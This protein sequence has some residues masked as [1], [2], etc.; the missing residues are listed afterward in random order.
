MRGPQ[1]SDTVSDTCI[2]RSG[3][4]GR[5]EGGLPTSF[6]SSPYRRNWC[7]RPGC[8]SWCARSTQ[9]VVVAFFESFE[10][11]FPNAFALFA[12]VPY[13]VL[14]ASRFSARS[15]LHVLAAFSRAS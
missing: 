9:P 13:L 12:F 7:R 10:T 14:K 3:H 5:D 8:G 6:V 11:H 15:A 2:V 4:P 1:V